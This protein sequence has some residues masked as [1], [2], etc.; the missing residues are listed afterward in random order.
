MREG[1]AEAQTQLLSDS[2]GE[3]TESA[4]DAVLKANQYSFDQA[5]IG[6]LIG[7]GTGNGATAR[8][9]GEAFVNEIK[10]RGETARYFYYDAAWEGV[11]VEYYIGYSAMG[12]WSADEAAKHLGSAIMRLQAAK[13]LQ[14]N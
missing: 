14:D 4:V 1:L 10:R 2:L 5:G 7:Y 12:P 9:I 8:Q 11:S 6:V 3:R 13:R